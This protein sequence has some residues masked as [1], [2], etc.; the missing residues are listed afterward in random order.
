MDHGCHFFWDSRWG[1]EVAQEAGA[2]QWQ[3]ATGGVY[4]HTGAYNYY[5]F[6]HGKGQYI[7]QTAASDIFPFDGH[8]CDNRWDYFHISD[9][10]TGQRGPYIPQAGLTMDTIALPTPH[11]LV[12]VAGT[13]PNL[14]RVRNSTGGTRRMYIQLTSSLT[15]ST[16]HYLLVKRSD[17]GV[18]DSNTMEM[19]VAPLASPF[20]A[21]LTTIPN[22]KFKRIRD[23]G[24]YLVSHSYQ[25]V[26]AAPDFNYYVD[27]KDGVNAYYEAPGL[28][29]VP[30]STHGWPTPIIPNDAIPPAGTEKETFGL[31]F[32]NGLGH[33]LPQSG[34]L[35]MAFVPWQDLTGGAASQLKTGY[36][37]RWGGGGTNTHQIYSSLSNQQIVYQCLTGGVTQAYLQ[38]PTAEVLQGV[39]LG[40]VG[41]WGYRTGTP[42]FVMALNGVIRE[43]DT[44][45]T[46]PTQ[47]GATISIGATAGFASPAAGNLWKAATG[48][49]MLSRADCAHLSRWMQKQAEDLNYL[50]ITGA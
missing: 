48:T 9:P 27:W 28:Q 45:G 8:F 21:D 35:A 50:G 22:I 38:V 47:A 42:Q 25:A 39:P 2:Y 37:I 14:T 4:Q 46:L 41:T 12:P 43:V 49:K 33:N 20:G 5:I 29:S 23:D 31:Y 32:N 34:W 36:Q 6:D 24:W 30:S 1:K 17:G 15:N 7:E 26:P 40:M 11:I 10:P 19:G 13:P 3:G 18:V 16:V 44:S